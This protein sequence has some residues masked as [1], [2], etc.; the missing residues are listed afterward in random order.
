[1]LLGALPIHLF[2]HFFCRMYHLATMHRFTD[3]QTD[4]W[5]HDANIQSYCVQYDHLKI[6]V[7]MVCC[8]CGHWLQAGFG[9]GLTLMVAMAGL[10]LYTAYRIMTSPNS[11]SEFSPICNTCSRNFYQKVAPMHVTEIVRLIGR[12]C[13]KVPGSRN[14][15]Q[16]EL[17]SVQCKFLVQVYSTSSWTFFS[18]AGR[19]SWGMK[20]CVMPLSSLHFPPLSRPVASLCLAI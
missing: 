19:I 18:P 6:A 4:R 20:M 3:R 12:L 1:M 17:C 16:I 2:R 9:C 13:L 11:A 5:R 15:H 10:M 14:L 8:V 7:K